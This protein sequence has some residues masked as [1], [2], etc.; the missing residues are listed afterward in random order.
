[1]EEGDKADIPECHNWSTK[2]NNNAEHEG[3]TFLP[4]TKMLKL[5]Q[6]AQGRGTRHVVYWNLNE[7]GMQ[8]LK[9]NL[10]IYENDVLQV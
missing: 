5:L 6:G 2:N 3:N 10:I 9:V 8:P 7:T 1:M 4:A